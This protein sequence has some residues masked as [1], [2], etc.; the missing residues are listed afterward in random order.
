MACVFDANRSCVSALGLCVSMCCAFLLL[1]RATAAENMADLSGPGDGCNRTMTID[2]GEQVPLP[3]E[4]VKFP[5]ASS[6]IFDV[7]PCRDVQVTLFAINVT[8]EP[9]AD[10]IKF[11][12]NKNGSGDIVIT[13]SE[14]N[15]KPSNVTE[16]LPL[17]YCKYSI[18]WKDG[19]IT[20][21]REG[22]G[23][24]PNNT[25]ERVMSQELQEN[26]QVY[27]IFLAYMPE[28][29]ENSSSEWRIVGE[30]AE[31]PIDSSSMV[32]VSHLA[33]AVVAALLCGI[34][35]GGFCVRYGPRLIQYVRNQITAAR[36]KRKNPETTEAAPEEMATLV[37]DQTSSQDKPPLG[38]TRSD[39]LDAPV[40]VPELV[41]PGDNP[42]Q[43]NP[44]PPRKASNAY[45]PYHQMGGAA[46]GKESS[47]VIT[48]T[49]SDARRPSGV[50]GRIASSPLP[51]LPGEVTK[52]KPKSAKEET[53]EPE[54]C[55]INADA[56]VYEG[57][58]HDAPIYEN[59]N[60]GM[61]ESLQK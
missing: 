57:V 50:G 25:W 54:E 28:V 7:R 49:P 18:D 11:V 53:S 60:T 12:I 21:L 29:G 14:A 32:S 23:T 13:H 34:I 15:T 38:P 39:N 3:Q 47:D 51:A 33:G 37:E 5:E 30:C 41:L 20:L 26:L 40:P 6:L 17:S 61:Y 58:R 2:A 8:D 46:T 52:E 22:N 45:T 35:L 43:P 27:D 36:H 4:Y 56:H 9:R 55:Y 44:K 10:V 1:A 31:E 19:N 48:A 24:T 42:P 59:R 16:A